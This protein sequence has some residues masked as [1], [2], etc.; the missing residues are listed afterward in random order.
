MPSVIDIMKQ[1]PLVDVAIDG[2]TLS[3]KCEYL[4]PGGSIKDRS[5]LYCIRRARDR[6]LLRPGQSVVEMTSGNMG[7]GLAIVCAHLGHP[8]TAVMSEGNSEPRRAQL[9]AL[10]ARV[11]LA[12]QVDGSP[13]RVTGADIAAAAD[14]ARRMAVREGAYYVD[15]FNNDAAVWGHEHE[16]GQEIWDQT[17]GQLR[18]FCAAVGTG[19]TFTGI[20]RRLKARDRS[21]RCAVVEPKGC[22]F[23]A[24]GRVERPGHLMQ[25]AGYGLRPPHFDPA[26]ADD[27]AAVDDDEI[28]T[29]KARLARDFGLFVGFSSAANVA[30]ALHLAKAQGLRQGVVTILC[31]TGFKYGL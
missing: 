18:L 14:E 24:T 4:L 28:Q 23:L 6:G 17:R 11:V 29:T 8:F 7:A 31:D 21:V 3:L 22:E 15:Q 13:G 16:T 25:G 5:A 2:V 26:L 9:R 27:Y 10:G 12:P 1:T 20:A 30:A 19:G